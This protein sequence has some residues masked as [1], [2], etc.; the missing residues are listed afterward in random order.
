MVCILFW[1]LFWPTVRKKCSSDWKITRK[2]Y[3]KVEMSEEFSKHNS[4]MSNKESNNSQN[5]GLE[6]YNNSSDGIFPNFSTPL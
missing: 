4:R 6:D 2:K 5:G 3:S 1:K